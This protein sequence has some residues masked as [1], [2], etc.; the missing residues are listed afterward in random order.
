MEKKPCRK[1]RKFIGI[2]DLNMYS[3]IVRDPYQTEAN[4]NLSGD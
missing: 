1:S 3:D 4:F 2:T